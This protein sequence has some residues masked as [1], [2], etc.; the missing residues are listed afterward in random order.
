[1]VLSQVIRQT[2]GHAIK[3]EGHPVAT[4]RCYDHDVTYWVGHCAGTAPTP[5][6]A[7]QGQRVILMALFEAIME[8]PAIN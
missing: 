7:L 8:R 2:R 1:M 5:W 4:M 3:P 6:R